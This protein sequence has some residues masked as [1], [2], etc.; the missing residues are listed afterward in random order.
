MTEAAED[1]DGR[2][3]RAIRSREAVVDAVLDLLRELDEKPS[4]QAIADRA[5]VSLRTVF[6]LFDDIDTLL[7]S[8]VA[9]QVERVR[10]LFDPL[11]VDGSVADRITALVTHRDTLFEQIAHVRRAALQRAEHGDIG[12]WLGLSRRLLREQATSLFGPELDA[13]PARERRVV[14]EAL[15]VCVGFAAWNALR[16]EQGLD[17]ATARATTAHLLTRLLTPAP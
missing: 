10:P 2:R 7:A 15:D 14:V 1:L 17:S 12:A 11:D 6:R 8:A 5:G 16:V 4:A 3:Q 9:H 13:L